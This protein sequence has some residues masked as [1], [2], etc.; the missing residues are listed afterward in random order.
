MSVEVESPVRAT[1]AR[2]FN[3]AAELGVDKKENDGESFGYG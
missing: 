3:I 2:G 1:T